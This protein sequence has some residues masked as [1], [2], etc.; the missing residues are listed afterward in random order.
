MINTF[1]QNIFVYFSYSRFFGAFDKEELFAENYDFSFESFKI[2]INLQAYCIFVN[3]K[4]F[5]SITDLLNRVNLPRTKVNTEAASQLF[6]YFGW[7]QVGLE[8]AAEVNFSCTFEP[9]NGKD[10]IK[11]KLS[12]FNEFEDDLSLRLYAHLL[13]CMQ[14]NVYPH[15]TLEDLMS[16]LNIKEYVSNTILKYKIVACLNRIT[17]I[18]QQISYHL[19]SPLFDRFHKLYFVKKNAI[20]RIRNKSRIRAKILYD[21][22]IGRLACHRNLSKKVL[23]VGKIECGAIFYKGAW[24]RNNKKAPSDGPFENSDGYHTWRKVK[25]IPVDLESYFHVAP[26]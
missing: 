5:K 18:D 23:Y 12:L 2:L 9:S 10:I 15:E 11:M 19:N 14:H 8:Q 26:L 3:K 1:D 16:A 20:D 24:S 13:Y 6:V 21:D 25:L 4:P 22:L 17:F 7:Q